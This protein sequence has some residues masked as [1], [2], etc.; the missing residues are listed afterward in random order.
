[1]AKKKNDNERKII[2]GNYYYDTFGHQTLRKNGTMGPTALRINAE[3][4]HGGKRLHISENEYEGLKLFET[5]V[6]SEYDSIG[7]KAKKSRMRSVQSRR[8]TAQAKSYKG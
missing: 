8:L 2:D 7:E 4:R 1:M 5:K 6:K 3:V